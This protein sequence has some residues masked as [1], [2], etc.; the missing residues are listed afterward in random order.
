MAQLRGPSLGPSAGGPPRQLVVLLHGV[1]ADGQGPDRAGADAGRGV[2][3]TPRF[4]AP[5]RPAALRPRPLRPAVVQPPGPSARRPWIPGVARAAPLRG[6]FVDAELTRH[7]LDDAPPGP[8]GVLPGHDDGA[9]SSARGGR[10]RWPRSWA[11]RVHCSAQGGL[12]AEVREPAAG[13][14]DPRRRGRRGAGRRRCSTPSPG[15][16][17]PKFRCNGSCAPACRTA[18]I[19]TGI[20]AR[21]PVPARDAD[22]ARPAKRASI[23]RTTSS[24]A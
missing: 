3:R 23:R 11:S 16:R 4:V 13:H 12:A 21:R 15:C 6:A 5:G 8:G 24:R 20:A 17:R 10:A 19:P 7:G 9:A 18:S 22:A 1:G 2:C 14:A